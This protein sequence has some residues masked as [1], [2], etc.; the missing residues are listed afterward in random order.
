MAASSLSRGQRVLCALLVVLL[1]TWADALKLE[2]AAG[3]PERCIRNWVAKDTLVVVTATVSGSKGDGMMVNMHI[4]DVMGN[5]YGR[6]KDLAGEQ[7]TVFT[8]HADASFDVCFENILSGSKSKFALP[9]PSC[10]AVGAWS[11]V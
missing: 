5:D 8:S 3:K 10:T 1:A 11:A 7:R 4:R 6:P 9:P 2:L